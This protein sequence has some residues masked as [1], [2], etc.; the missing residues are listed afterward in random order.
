MENTHVVTPVL[1]VILRTV[2]TN[3]D[4]RG[5]VSVPDSPM[6]TACM[7]PAAK[8]TPAGQKVAKVRSWPWNRAQQ[9][10]KTG[11]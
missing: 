7:S 2:K 5:D 11:A 6:Q 9:C 4:D 10:S 1:R 8:P 3:I